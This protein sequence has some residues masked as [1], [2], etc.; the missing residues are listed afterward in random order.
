M[1]I[2]ILW[3]ASLGEISTPLGEMSAIWWYVVSYLV[4]FGGVS[5]GSALQK[6]AQ[7]GKG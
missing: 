1:L 2:A 5:L 4:V 6:K 3:V 7:A